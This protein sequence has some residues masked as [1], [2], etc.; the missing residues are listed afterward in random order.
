MSARPYAQQMQRV[1]ASVASR[2]DP[3]IHPLLTVA[4]T[5]ARTAARSSSSSP[6]TRGSA[7][8]S[9]PTSSRARRPTSRAAREACALGLVGRKGRDFFGRRGFAVAVRAGRHLPEAALRRCAGDCADGDRRVH[10]RTGRPRGA[11]LQRVPV[12]HVAARGRSISC[13]RSRAADVEA[14]GVALAESGRLPVRAVAAGDLQRAAAALHRGAGVPGA[15]RIERGVLRRADDGDG[16]GTKNSADMIVEPDAA[17]EQGPA[18]GDYARDHRG[19][20]RRAGAVG[21]A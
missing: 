12:G 14:Q 21:P 16:H 2:V 1:L 6:A 17:H 7:A 4:R 13:C 3:S 10:R 19:G 18:G 20:V 9:T 8:A 15:A 5:P 11:G